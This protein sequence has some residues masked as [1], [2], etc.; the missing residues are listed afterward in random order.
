MKFLNR[1]NKILHA[2]IILIFM[3]A[4]IITNSPQILSKASAQS[5]PNISAFPTIKKHPEMPSGS[6]ATAIAILLNYHGVQIT[7]EEIGRELPTEPLPVEVNNR[8]IGGDPSRGFIGD[9]FSEQGLGLYQQPLARILGNKIPVGQVIDRSGRPFL[10]VL[11]EVERGNPMIVW[12]TEGLRPASITQFWWTIDNN[13][14]Q[15][16]GNQTTVVLFDFDA[17]SVYVSDPNTGQIEAYNRVVFERIWRDV[18]SRAIGIDI[19]ASGTPTATSTPD[20]AAPDTSGG[21]NYEEERRKILREIERQRDPSLVDEAGDEDAN[22][23]GAVKGV[24]SIVIW[25]VI[26]AT[27][28]FLA[29]FTTL[30]ILTLKANKKAQ[31]NQQQ[32]ASDTSQEQDD[33]MYN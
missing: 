12:V 11:S 20:I 17:D 28:I 16:H 14:I 24:P 6:E 15:W 33:D 1:Y 13:L 26:I 27:F 9:P 21:L 7:K 32:V 25:V 29:S 10:A 30:L 18:G 19:T 8:Q 3:L 23:D 4:F 31:D 2:A 5:P 22:Q